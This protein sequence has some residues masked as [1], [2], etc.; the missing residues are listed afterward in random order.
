[1]K[2]KKKRLKRLVGKKES[3]LVLRSNFIH[4][5]CDDEN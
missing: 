5:I 2:K 3:G 4:T 1:M